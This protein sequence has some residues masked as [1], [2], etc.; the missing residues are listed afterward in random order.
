MTLLE[1]LLVADP[2]SVDPLKFSEIT[3]VMTAA[4]GLEF[5]AVWGLLGVVGGWGERFWRFGLVL[6][7]FFLVL[8]LGMRPGTLINH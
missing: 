5:G 3:T 1:F 6:A 7:L 2:S 4:G 8:A